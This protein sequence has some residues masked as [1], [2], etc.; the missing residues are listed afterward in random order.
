MTP[1]NSGLVAV[2]W[3]RGI[4][5]ASGFDPA[6]VA[7]HLPTGDTGDALLRLGWVQVAVVGGS[8]DIDIPVRRPVVQ[9]DA[10]VMTQ[11]GGK[12]PWGQAWALAEVVRLATEGV[13]QWRRAVTMP[14]GVLSANGSAS[15]SCGEISSS[16]GASFR[17]DR[18]LCVQSISSRSASCS[19]ADASSASLH[20]SALS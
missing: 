19:S 6:R 2:A 1:P 11:P 12:P 13:H 16:A 10:W 18:S 5:A 9:I 14:A 7:A 8:P 17:A 3:V 4:T 15:R 20:P